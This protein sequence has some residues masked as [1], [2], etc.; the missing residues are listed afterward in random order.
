MWIRSARDFTP[1]NRGGHELIMIIEGNLSL[2]SYYFRPYLF[3]ICCWIVFIF[4]GVDFKHRSLSSIQT[5]ATSYLQQPLY[6][7]AVHHHPWSF[8]TL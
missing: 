2:V 8:T 3:Y 6:Y 5:L 7:T 1:I 4:I